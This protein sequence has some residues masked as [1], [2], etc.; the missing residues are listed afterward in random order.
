MSEIGDIREAN[1][2]T[3]LPNQGANVG[4][5]FLPESSVKTTGVELGSTHASSSQSLSNG[6]SEQSP[7][8]SGSPWDSV[9]SEDID[10]VLVDPYKRPKSKKFGF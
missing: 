8:G 6:S 2:I 7:A 4:K 9:R 3:T 10:Q 5:V 1:K